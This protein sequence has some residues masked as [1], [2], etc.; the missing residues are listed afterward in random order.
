M[1]AKTNFLVIGLQNGPV[2]IVNE[3]STTSMLSLVDKLL[4]KVSQ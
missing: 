3:R 1:M 2:N 4:I